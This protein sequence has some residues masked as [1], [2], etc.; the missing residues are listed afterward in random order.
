MTYPSLLQSSVDSRNLSLTVKGFLA[1]LIP[2]A[3]FASHYLGFVEINEGD[4][5][6]FVEAAGAVVSSAMVLYGV[7]RKIAVKFG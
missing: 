3:L 1:G 6:A 4:L 5:L 2:L 7:A